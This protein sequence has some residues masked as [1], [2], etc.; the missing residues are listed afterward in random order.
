IVDR[1][2]TGEGA[3]LLIACDYDL[4]SLDLGESIAVDGACLTV[5]EIAGEGFQIEASPETLSRTTLGEREVGDGVH[6]ERALAAGDRLGGH[7]VQGHVD[8]VGRLLERSREENAWLLDFEAPAELAPYLIEKGSIALDGVSLTLNAVDG[9]RFGVAIIPHTARHTNLA[10]YRTGRRVNLEA[11]IIGK[12][13]EKMVG[14]YIGAAAR[15]D[16]DS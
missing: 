6:L 9:R 15:D 1:D 16:H 12:Y 14:P 11:D 10:D 4:E 7:I 8:G 3:A 2:T 5:A 13:V